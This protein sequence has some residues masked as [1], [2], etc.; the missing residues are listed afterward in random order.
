[1]QRKRRNLWI[2]FALL[3]V[4]VFG[5][6]LLGRTAQALIRYAPGAEHVVVPVEGVAPKSVQSSWHAP[7][8][9]HRR[10]Q[11]V[12]IF[13][14]RGTPVLSAT[15]GEV[16]RIGHD[17]LGGNVVWVAGQ[18]ASLY[19]YA[20][21]DSFDPTLRQNAQIH[22]GDRIG[23]VGD[24]GNAKGTPPHLHFGIYPFAYAFRAIDPAPILRLRGH[25]GRRA[26]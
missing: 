10:H 1:M 14:R 19:Y 26:P 7:R 2:A 12:D 3:C 6:S 18:G 11:G 22:P 25:Q 13:A 15:A 16:V 23:L 4:G 21:L 17:R 5:F 8:S 20:H 24:T 9:G